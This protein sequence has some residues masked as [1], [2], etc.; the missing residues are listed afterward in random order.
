MA[1]DVRSR[2]FRVEVTAETEDALVESAR[3]Q[4]AEYWRVPA[5]RIQ[6]NIGVVLTGERDPFPGHLGN[7]AAPVSYR[8]HADCYL[9]ENF[10]PDI[11]DEGVRAP[12]T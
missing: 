11:V 7:Y 2:H 12:V 4:A 5:R 8:A 6:V 9:H 10:P 3:L 1:E